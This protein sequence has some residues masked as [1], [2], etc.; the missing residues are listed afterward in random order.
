[1]YICAAAFNDCSVV[2][3]VPILICLRTRHIRW[4]QN[5][6]KP[7][8]FPKNLRIH[9]EPLIDIKNENDFMDN[10]KYKG[11]EKVSLQYSWLWWT[12]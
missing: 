8:K 12:M 7:V 11:A 6:E 4:L 9:L 1:M 10:E 2:R 3:W 5:S